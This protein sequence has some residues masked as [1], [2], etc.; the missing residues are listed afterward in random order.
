M[1]SKRD[2]Q[3][4]FMSPVKK[5]HAKKKVRC[6]VIHRVRRQKI[7]KSASAKTAKNDV[8]KKTSK[9]LH[10]AILR[11]LVSFQTDFATKDYFI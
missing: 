3:I 8:C 5:L 9:R 6:P 4:H 1:T 2:Q 10:V 11:I 7:V